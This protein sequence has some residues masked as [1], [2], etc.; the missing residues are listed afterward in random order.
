MVEKEKI[1][2]NL[3]E[4]IFEIKNDFLTQKNSYYYEIKN[5]QE[6]LN[7]KNTE[8][9]YEKLEREN[10]NLNEKILDLTK[11]KESQKKSWKI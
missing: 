2:I 9:Y 6:K 1:I 8:I 4:K 11:K 7:Q 5:M 10:F 3:Q